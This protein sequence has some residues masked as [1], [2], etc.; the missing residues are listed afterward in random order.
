MAIFEDQKDH[1][2][3]IMNE[4]VYSMKEIFGVSLCQVIFFGSY[5]RG[6]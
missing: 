2:K 3:M 5:T 1:V 4:I 6:E